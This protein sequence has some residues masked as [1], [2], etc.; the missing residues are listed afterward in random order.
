MDI[1]EK[2]LDTRQKYFEQEMQNEYPEDHR[3]YNKRQA[4]LILIKEKFSQHKEELRLDCQSR[5][6]EIMQNAFEQI[7]ENRNDYQEFVA[8][9]SAKIGVTEERAE[10]DFMD[11]V[12]E[13]V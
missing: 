2:K 12:V 6:T 8:E 4:R 1:F 3:E 11:N 10:S 9:F 7:Q 5:F 13:F